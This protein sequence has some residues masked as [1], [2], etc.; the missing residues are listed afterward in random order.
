[1]RLG[2]LPQAMASYKRY[3]ALAPNDKDAGRIGDEL[4]KLEFRM[5]QAARIQNRSGVWVGE[6]GMPY[7]A[8]A[9][10]SSLLLRCGRQPMTNEE[11]VANT[12]LGGEAALPLR[13]LRLELQGERVTGTSTRSEV[14]VGKCVVPAET[15]E[16]E[17]TYDEAAGRLELRIPRSRFQARTSLNIFLDPVG[18]AGV[19]VRGKDTVNVVLYG[20]LPAGGI[21]AQVALDYPGHLMIGYHPWQGR[22]GLAARQTLDPR[23]KEIGFQEKDEILA[24]DGVA[25]NTL[26]PAEAIRSLRGVPGSE[27]CLTVLHPKAKQPVTLTFPRVAVASPDLVGNRYESWGN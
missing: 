20:P 22:L 9:K 16:V 17:G 4:I 5:E 26:G 11:L 8:T 3:L 14:P 21:G 15:V 25:V 12:F 27:I 13:E 19:S 2:R 7:Q 1:M 10:D 24:I 6:L 18:C 23:L